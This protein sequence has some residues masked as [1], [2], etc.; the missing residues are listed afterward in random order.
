MPKPPVNKDRGDEGP[1][2]TLTSQTAPATQ[3]VRN[4]EGCDGPP[5]AVLGAAGTDLC[6]RLTAL[7]FDSHHLATVL[8]VNNAAVRRL[9]LEAALASGQSFFARVRD[10]VLA[11]DFDDP[12]S[13]AGAAD[14]LY[15]SARVRYGLP[16][17][18]VGSGQ[19][20]RRHC[21]VWPVSAQERSDLASLARKLG[22]DVRIDIRPPLT[23]HR[24]AAKGVRP[25]LLRGDQ[26]IL[27]FGLSGALPTR[28]WGHRVAS[29]SLE[30][31]NPYAST[32]ELV[33][34]A[35]MAAVNAGWG[36]DEFE[37]MLACGGIQLGAAYLERVQRRGADRTRKWLGH[38]VWTSAEQKVASNPSRRRDV[39][40]EVRAVAARVEE[41][42]WP[43]RGGASQRAVY[44]SLLAKAE[45]VGDLSVRA[46]IRD[47]MVGAGLPSR[48]TVQRAL[49]ALLKEGLIDPGRTTEADV[50]ETGRRRW[51]SRWAIVPAPSQG[52]QT[53]PSWHSS[54]DMPPVNHDAFLN[55]SGLGK[56]VH[57]VLTALYRAPGTTAEMLEKSLGLQ[58]RTV[59]RHLG[60]L[61]VHGLAETDGEG[62]WFP[63]KRELDS[64]AADLGNLGRSARLQTQVSLERQGYDDAHAENKDDGRVGG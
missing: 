18:L 11:A 46:S 14:R 50:R 39:P 33:G 57:R 31:P 10:G 59:R 26:L 28:L 4:S 12:V 5:P 36:L 54:A 62:H 52:Q 13:A 42:A 15:W 27:D 38:Q 64:V 60:C 63:T 51:T 49:K 58:R 45:A 34:A 1:F 9:P 40:P 6:A 35:A 7:L 3:R 29:G 47:L 44:L 21:F 25:K 43:S 2:P 41:I 17:L 61:A 48:S 16:A 53:N 8:D 22:A 55:H 24:W 20:H 23:P 19:P 32:S 56:N 37:E 30:G